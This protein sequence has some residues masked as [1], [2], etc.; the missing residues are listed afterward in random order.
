M[1]ELYGHP[2]SSFTWKPLIALYER[3]V[4]FTFH[5]VDPGHPNNQALIDRLS[6]TGH[7][8]ALVDGEVEV[9]QSNAVIEYLDLHGGAAPMVPE[10]RREAIEAR[11]LA[12]VF[13]NYINVPLQRVVKEAF[14]PE[15][16]KD[17]FG[18]TAA[19]KTLTKTYAWLET[20]LADRTWAISNRFSIADC[21]AAPALFYADW[22]EPIPAGAVAEY[23]A[24][25]L[26][27]DSVVRVV[28]EARPYRKLFPLGAP[29][30]D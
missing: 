8:P 2:F 13:D 14:R 17:P 23:R 20:K 21:A 19:R 29:D 9:T 4:P 18:V 5:T 22:V 3:E 26:A 6:P 7:F 10:D 28:N 16:A 27:R 12:E 11:M 15:D 24:R 30:R 25:L 1:L